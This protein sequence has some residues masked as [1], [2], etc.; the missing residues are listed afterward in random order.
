MRVQVRSQI[1]VF[2]EI[3]IKSAQRGSLLVPQVTI[4]IAAQAAFRLAC[5]NTFQMAFQSALHI[6]S[7]IA[8]P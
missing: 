3:P 5:L 6:A 4:H 7:Q 2:E 8:H 1:S